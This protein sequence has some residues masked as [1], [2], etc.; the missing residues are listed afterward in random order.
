MR[1][2]PPFPLGIADRNPFE[3]F[4][5]AAALVQGSAVLLGIADPTSIS[6]AL[7]PYLRVIWAI[8]LTSGGV[9]AL[10][11]LGWPGDPFTAVEIKRVGL[12]AAGAGTL[13][14]GLAAAFLGSTGIAVAVYNLAFTSACFWRTI[15]LTLR[16][17]G[18]RSTLAAIRDSGDGDGS[19]Q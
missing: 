15:Q 7:P 19:R 3:A 5:L 16:L 6:S 9:C 8:L 14:Y 18:I 2:L 12:V 17:R 10:S 1:V 13:V 4:L 11:G